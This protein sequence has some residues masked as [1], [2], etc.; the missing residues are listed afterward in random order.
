M[1][2][3]N[4]VQ[5]ESQWEDVILTPTGREN[6]W[7]YL[8]SYFQTA[9][10]NDDVK[11]RL[12]LFRWYTDLTWRRITMLSNDDFVKIA[13][14]RQ[15]SLALLLGFD[16]LKEIFSYLSLRCPADE[17]KIQVYSKA[18][19]VFLNSGAYVGEL[20]GKS[21]YLKDVI[22]EVK[23]FEQKRLSTLEKAEIKAKIVKILFPKNDAIF[24]KYII[25]E[26]TKI[27]G[28]LVELIIFFLEVDATQIHLVVEEYNK[29]VE[30]G[31]E[32]A[33]QQVQNVSKKVFNID[34]SKKEIPQ[35]KPPETK[36]LKPTYSQLR[37]DVNRTTSVGPNEERPAKINAELDRLATEFNDEKI[38]ELF[39]F[40]EQSGK[41]EWNEVLLKQ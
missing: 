10:H 9:T 6:V 23:K 16:V 32:F 36:L 30:V 18:K 37:R 40:N 39:Y 31:V 25:S 4:I 8:H 20:G 17:D 26:P 3:K 7:M 15:V 13:I 12:T 14:G 35:Q 28:M 21:F 27:A 41:F 11:F 34:T 1:D 2:I 33:I 38:R 29:E 22:V 24:N 19:D 5:L